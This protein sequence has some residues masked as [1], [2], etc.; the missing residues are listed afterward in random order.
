MTRAGVRIL[1]ERDPVWTHSGAGIFRATRPGRCDLVLGADGVHSQARPLVVGAD[2]VRPVG[3]PA[4]HRPRTHRVLAQT[5]RRD[6]TRSLPPALRD[7][8]PRRWGRDIFHANHRPLLEL[9]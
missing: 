8:V 5:H 3:Q 4:R 1:V 9:P 6:R 2:V 7:L